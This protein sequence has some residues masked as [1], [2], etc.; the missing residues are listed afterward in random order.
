MS[1]TISQSDRLLVSLFS[2]TLK[3]ISSGISNKSL[4]YKQEDIANFVL[5]EENRIL[6]LI[7][8]EDTSM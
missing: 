6:Y 3:K 7:E 5:H 2:D 1:E 4:K 8:T